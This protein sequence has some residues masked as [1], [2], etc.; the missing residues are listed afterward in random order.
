MKD[1]IVIY[2]EKYDGN[3]EVDRN[4]Y[5]GKGLKN[6][7]NTWFFNSIMQWLTATRDLYFAYWDKESR[8]TGRGYVFND[9]LREFLLDM[10]DSRGDTINPVDLFKFISK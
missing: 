7:G 3:K 5:S 4:V 8:Q 6:L 2:R 9:I 10:R 1:L